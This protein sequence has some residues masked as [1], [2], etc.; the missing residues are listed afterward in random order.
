MQDQHDR[1]STFKCTF[2]PHT[3]E[4]SAVI[5]FMLFWSLLSS[6]GASCAVSL[7]ILSYNDEPSRTSRKSDGPTR[8]TTMSHD[9]T[10][11]GAAMSTASAMSVVNTLPLPWCVCGSV[12]ACKVCACWCV[13]AHNY[14]TQVL[15]FDF[16]CNTDVLTSFPDSHRCKKRRWWLSHAKMLT[17]Q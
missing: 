17:T 11:R 14:K 15:F 2:N 12:C 8:C 5:L 16:T 9:A 7:T 6:S 10:E 13:V 3:S 4:L 1:K